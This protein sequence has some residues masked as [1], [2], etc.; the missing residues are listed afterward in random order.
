MHPIARSLVALSTVSLAVACAQVLDIQEAT[1]D[2]TGTGGAPPS[3]NAPVTCGEYCDTVM[4]NCAGNFE[5]YTSKEMCMAVCAHLPRGARADDSVNTVG[6]RLRN[7]Q[8]A[9]KL[10]QAEKDSQ[11]STA[12]PGGN[13]VCGTNCEGYCSIMLPTCAGKFDGGQQGCLTLCTRRPDSGSYNDAMSSGPDVQ[14]LLYHVSAATL[15]PDPHCAH[16]IGA[17]PCK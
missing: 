7:A 16:A 13:G 2:T 3:P 11:C 5:Q 17:T 12:G 9:A 14:C 10:G 1:L 6:C 15:A 4:K 8:L